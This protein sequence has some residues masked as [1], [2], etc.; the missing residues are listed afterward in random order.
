MGIFNHGVTYA[1]FLPKLLHNSEETCAR[2]PP[3]TFA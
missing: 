1:T 3:K 2:H